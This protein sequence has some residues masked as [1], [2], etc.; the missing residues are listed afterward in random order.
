MEGSGIG[1][2]VAAADAGG[3]ALAGDGD[4]QGNGQNGLGD[5]AAVVEQLGQVR[6]GNEELRKFLM[7]N[8]LGEG[9]H[10]WPEDG[11]EPFDL[12]ELGFDATGLDAGAD[13]GEQFDPHTDA[14]AI[15][16]ALGGLVQEAMAPLQDEVRQHLADAQREGQVRDL[17]GE[18][19]DLND[20][21]TMRDVLDSARTYVEAAGLPP[22][23][24][25]QPFMVRL[26]YM[27]GLAQQ[28]AAA[29]SDDE[30]PHAAY[31]E[32]GGGAIGGGRGAASMAQQILGA[33]RPS[34]LPFP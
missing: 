20:E 16:Q 32:G 34:V 12:G 29:E 24:A 21:K 2:G 1:G 11:E 26:T 7:D 23:L 8:N 9:D 6:E 5:L 14:Q 17:L 28:A 22:E 3:V 30:P 31:L 33:G 18:F 19:P 13:P 10:A 27:A 25:H 15:N 4:A